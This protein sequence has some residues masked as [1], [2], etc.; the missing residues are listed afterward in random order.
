MCSR[1]EPRPCRL[2]PGHEGTRQV[3]PVHPSMAP[4]M[5]VVHSAS[6]AGD[7]MA[8]EKKRRA[9]K[10]AGAGRLRRLRQYFNR[11]PPR[12]VATRAFHQG[13]KARLP[14]ATM[15]RKVTLAGGTP[16]LAGLRSLAIDQVPLVHGTWIDSLRALRA[17]GESPRFEL[18]TPTLRSP[19]SVSPPEAVTR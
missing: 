12:S 4:C 13:S 18:A 1:P 16:R 2:N 6:L 5:D 19:A 14:L 11:I 8:S 3:E 7:A 10:A 9:P 15:E 17:E